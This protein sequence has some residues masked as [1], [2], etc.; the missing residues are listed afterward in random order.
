MYDCKVYT[1]EFNADSF[2]CQGMFAYLQSLEE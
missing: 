1:V 2:L